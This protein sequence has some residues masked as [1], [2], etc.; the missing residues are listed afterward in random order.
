MHTHT[1]GCVHTYPPTPPSTWIKIKNNPRMV[2]YPFNPS[3]Q[4][5]TQAYLSGFQ[6]SLIYAGSM[7]LARDV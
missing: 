7:R 2:V 4:E 1:Q 3:I 6:A 5:E